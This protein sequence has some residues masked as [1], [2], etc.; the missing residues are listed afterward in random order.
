MIQFRRLFFLLLCLGLI[1]KGFSQ[2]P[3]IYSESNISMVSPGVYQTHNCAF[4]GVDLWTDSIY[5]SYSWSTGATTPRIHLPNPGQAYSV[6]LT[7]TTGSNTYS[8][9]AAAA[10][11]G[12]ANQMTISP[13]MG[14]ETCVGDSLAIGTHFSPGFE[15]LI[16]SWGPSITQ[17]TDCDFFISNTCY[18]YSHANTENRYTR[19]TQPDGCVYPSFSQ[20]LMFFAH[21][22]PPVITQSND[23]L[24]ASGGSPRYVW[25]DAGMTAIPGATQDWYKPTVAGTYYVKADGSFSTPVCLSGVSTGYSFSPG[26]CGAS[27]TWMSDTT[28]QYSIIV[29]NNCTP[30]PTNGGTYLWDF[31]DGNT[32][33]QAYPQHQYAG[34]GTYNVCVTVTFGA[35]TQTFCDNIVVTNKVTFCDN[36]IVTNKVNAPF[37]INVVDPNAPVA[38]GGAMDT[39]VQVWPNPSKGLFYVDLTLETS[40]V[41][42]LRV[43]GLDGRLVQWIPSTRM[44]S[45]A[46]RLLVDGTAL[47]QGIYVL[48]LQIGGRLIVQKLVVGE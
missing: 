42:G 25:Y 45:G 11:V 24:Y 46:Q 2:A 35:C 37:T 1:T 29:L 15:T 38:I 40:E 12:Q 20:V 16:W 31:G 5:T 9:T 32:S 28:G 13:F 19:T 44:E 30:T 22:S 23:T 21:P 10:A 18:M 4:M 36:I 14:T 3:V 27:Y 39:G 17:S 47:A 33:T 7:V 41:V 34:A 26:G 48:E 6:T 43:L 8:S